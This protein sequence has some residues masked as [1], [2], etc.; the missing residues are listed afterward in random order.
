MWHID[1]TV[2]RLLDG[3]RAYL[4][5][6]ID[7]FSRRILAWRVADTFAPVNSVA[8]LLDASRGATSSDAIPV[9]LA[10]AGVENVNAQV[11]ALIS[12]GV[13]R[14]MLALTELTFSN[15]MIEAWWRALK[16]QWLFLHSLDS[17]ATVRR[18]V[19]F[20]VQE[21]NRVLPHSAFHG[22][23]P[24]EMYFGTGDAVPADLMSRAAAVRRTRGEANRSA[25]CATCPSVDAAA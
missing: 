20:Y 12:T 18:L 22:Q 17:V 14:R 3:T 6:V 9:V 1:T 10:D 2:I 25:S 23:T 5:A 8:V 16:H 4:H 19:E 7:N 11:D 24:D 13:L 21:H 15:S